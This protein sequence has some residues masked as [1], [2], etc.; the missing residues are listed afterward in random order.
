MIWHQS[1]ESLDRSQILSLY[2]SFP[3]SLSFL[4]VPSQIVGLSFLKFDISIISQ[5]IQGTRTSDVY[6]TKYLIFIIDYML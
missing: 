2:V 1:A 5:T 3:F 6:I 4:L